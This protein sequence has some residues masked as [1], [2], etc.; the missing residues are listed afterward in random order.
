[1]IATENKG[2]TATYT[3]KAVKKYEETR[4]KITILADKGTKERI[5]AVYNGSVSE[6]ITSLVYKQLEIDEQKASNK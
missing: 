3:R 1:M 4:D 5:K 2:K 6:Y